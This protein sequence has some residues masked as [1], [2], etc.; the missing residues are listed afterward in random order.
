[1]RKKGG[2]RTACR[3]VLL[4]HMAVLDGKVNRVAH[5]VNK[6]GSSNQ[7]WIHGTIATEAGDLEIIEAFITK[8]SGSFSGVG[9]YLDGSASVVTGARY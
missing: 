3:G 2:L 5:L 9:I 8:G 1:M 6:H 7:C 4:D